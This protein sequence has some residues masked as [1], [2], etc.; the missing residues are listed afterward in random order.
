[1]KELDSAISLSTSSP[2]AETKEPTKPE[3]PKKTWDTIFARPEPVPAPTK[4]VENT[5]Q[6]P[7]DKGT[8]EA[9]TNDGISQQDDE[10]NLDRLMSQAAQKC[11]D[12]RELPD[13]YEYNKR[14]ERFLSTDTI[15]DDMGDDTSTTVE[16]TSSSACPSK[17]GR[18]GNTRTLLDLVK[19]ADEQPCRVNRYELASLIR[20]SEGFITDRLQRIRHRDEV[21]HWFQ[22]H[23]ELDAEEIDHLITH[24]NNADRTINLNTCKFML[25]WE[26]H[27]HCAD[28]ME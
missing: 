16:A 17:L 11:P 8:Q 22:K 12:I 21:L 9:S 25:Q 2:T 28:T 27:R 13:Y 15:S 20:L 7:I 1:M 14:Q 5:S 24:C 19:S 3:P 4:P 26:D 23:L 18:S 6:T 10:N